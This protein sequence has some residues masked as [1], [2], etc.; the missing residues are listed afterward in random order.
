MANHKSALKRAR[1]NKVNRLRNA[2]S[3]T[4]AKSAVKA[5]RIAAGSKDTAKARETLREAVSA[6]QK[7]A[8]KG[9]IHKKRAARKASRL[10]RQVNKIALA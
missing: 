3:K 7:A 9:V 10:A 1:Q 6:L 4:R 5:V 8:A 2:V